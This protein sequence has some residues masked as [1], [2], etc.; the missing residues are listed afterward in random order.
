MFLK[1][2]KAVLS[3]NSQE[4]FGPVI[5]LTRNVFDAEVPLNQI[6]KILSVT[7][8]QVLEMLQSSLRLSYALYARRE[9]KSVSEA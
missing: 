4:T 1:G 5:F 9:G 3:E 2:G 8:E 6:R 7:S